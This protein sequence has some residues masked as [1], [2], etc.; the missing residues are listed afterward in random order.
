MIY[1]DSNATTRPA[2]AVV[3]A[4][5]ETL[6]QTWHNPSSIHRA[7]QSARRAVEQS[8]SRVAR[9]IGAR[10]RQ[11]VFTSGA[12]ESLHWAIRGLLELGRRQNKR[13]IVTSRLEHNAVVDFVEHLEARG[14][15]TVRWAPVTTEGAV[16]VDAMAP[17][18]DDSVA[19][20]CAQWA[21]N[22]TGVIQPI[23]AIGELCRSAG[24]PFLCDGAQWVGKMPADVSDAP[25]DA[26]TIS[27][28]KFHGPK[29]VGALWLRPGLSIPPAAPGA[30]ETGQR[31]GTEN[32]PGIVGMGVAANLAADWLG[33]EPNRAQGADRR[34]RFEEQL[35]ARIAGVVINGASS[36]AS[37]ARLWN[38]SNVGFEGVQ[39]EA[40]LIALSERGLCAS[41]GAACSSGSLDPSPILRAM[42]IPEPIAHGSLR[43]SLSRET[44]QADID[45]AIDIIAQCV[46]RVKLVHH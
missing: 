46:D 17:L 5:T 13:V 26:L 22:E 31:G 18:I 15:A 34:D 27:A 16:E 36:A 20:V 3:D 43:F 12:T 23:D 6:R 33:D 32:V 39:S 38:T 9:L 10:P 28:H 42:N 14:E 8:R 44:T 41:A 11:V 7:G 30:Q 29:G 40:L 21:N 19:L 37:T 2:D 4:V 1:L 25:F 24:V 35:H 45:Q